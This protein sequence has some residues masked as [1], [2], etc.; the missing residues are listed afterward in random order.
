MHNVKCVRATRGQ[1]ASAQPDWDMEP[2][3]RRSSQ[4]DSSPHLC[5]STIA[6]LPMYHLAPLHS[7]ST[8]FI[9]QRPKIL[10]QQPNFICAPN[11]FSVRALF[12]MK[13]KLKVKQKWG[14]CHIKTTHRIAV[15]LRWHVWEKRDDGEGEWERGGRGSCDS[16]R[17][18]WQSIFSPLTT[19]KE[20]NGCGCS[21]FP[22]FLLT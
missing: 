3:M 22:P 4:V 15:V 20:K 11:S 21:F 16:F 14:C 12:L 7:A 8:G 10:L 1:W 13:I 18:R 2:K 9:D 5:T 6:L 17:W 19:I